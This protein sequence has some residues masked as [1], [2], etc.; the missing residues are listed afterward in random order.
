MMCLFDVIAQRGEAGL[1]PVLGR[2]AASSLNRVVKLC[3]D[4]LWVKF[5]VATCLSEGLTAATAIVNPRRFEKSRCL[6]MRGDPLSDCR[7]QIE[8]CHGYLLK[9]NR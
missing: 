8:P 9:A 3:Q 5:T 7:V 1:C 2:L 6:G 4:L